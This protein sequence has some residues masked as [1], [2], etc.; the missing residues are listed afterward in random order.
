MPRHRILCG[1]HWMLQRHTDSGKEKKPLGTE[2]QPGWPPSAAAEMSLSSHHCAPSE[3]RKLCTLNKEPDCVKW[4]SITIAPSVLLHFPKQN[5]KTHLLWRPS[6]PQGSLLAHQ[7]SGTRAL[8][9]KKKSIRHFPNSMLV[10]ISF[11]QKHCSKDT[12]VAGSNIL[13]PTPPLQ[14]FHQRQRRRRQ[15]RAHWGS[16]WQATEYCKLGGISS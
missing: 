11:L 3:W 1:H 13:S 10:Q 9:R 4:G 15:F 6:L 14:E 12:Q 5:K 7:D 8:N 2:R 16:A